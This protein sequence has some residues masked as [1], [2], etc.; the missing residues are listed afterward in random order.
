MQPISA[1]ELILNPDGSIYHLNVRPE[2][3]ADTVLTVG[4]P[5]RVAR[6]SRHFDTIE[7]KVS[8]REFVTHTGWL[9]KKRLTV[10]S[11][12]IGTENIDIVMNELDALANIDFKTRLPKEIHKVLNIIRVGTSGTV[13]RETP[14]DSFV[15]SAFGLGLGNLMHFYEYENSAEELE[16]LAQIKNFAPFPAAIQPQIF[17]ANAALLELLTFDIQGITLTA[18]GFYAPQGRQLRAISKFTSENL[19]RLSDFQYKN[20]RITNFEMETSAIFG[21]AKVLGHRAVSCNAIIANRI[22]K[23]F[24]NDPT[25]TVDRLIQQVLENISSA[26]F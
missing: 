5:D 1:S 7:L 14:V 24:S 3:I 23:Q 19:N 10:L 12:G 8:R 17:A 11:T 13:W 6:I 18:P 15:T 26:Q 4:D 9:G 22:L 21:L 25:K 2:Q 16:I 20:W